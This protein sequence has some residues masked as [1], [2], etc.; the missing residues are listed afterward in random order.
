MNKS[1]FIVMTIAE[2]T[3]EKQSAVL[4]A[5]QAVAKAARSQEGCLEYRILCTAENPGT[6]VNFE[7]W[8]SVEERNSFNRGPDVI[9]F[10]AA[11]SGGF[12]EPPQPLVYQE[13]G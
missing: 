12:A 7:R 5:L 6:T 8:S 4:R 10:A 2:A 11:V 13:V 3:P 9:A 1:D